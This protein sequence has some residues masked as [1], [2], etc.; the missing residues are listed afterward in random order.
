VVH[1]YVCDVMPASGDLAPQMDANL[2]ANLPGLQR[3]VRVRTVLQRE[4]HIPGEAL[5]GG[6]ARSWQLMWPLTWGKE[7]WW[8]LEW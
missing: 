3:W 1:V 5:G 8:L 7:P 2:G 6:G 4:T